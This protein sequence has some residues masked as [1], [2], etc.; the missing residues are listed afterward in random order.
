M[1][2]VEP[3]DVG[4]ALAAVDELIAADSLV[5]GDGEVGAGVEVDEIEHVEH[6]GVGVGVAGGWRVYSLSL[7]DGPGTAGGSCW[8]LGGGYKVFP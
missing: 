1:H 8:H 5:G 7:G 4:R 2:E 6:L 3:P